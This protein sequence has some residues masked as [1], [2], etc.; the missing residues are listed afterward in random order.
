VLSS[1][2]KRIGPIEAAI[3]VLL[4]AGVTF[5]V[6]SLA[7]GGDKGPA[8]QVRAARAQSSTT[9]KPASGEVASVVVDAKTGK[10]RV[11]G[12][13]KAA[14]TG[15]K[16]E[17]QGAGAVAPAPA[18]APSSPPAAAT[19]STPS[20]ASAVG[21]MIVSPVT[22][23]T[24]DAPLLARVKAGHV[25]GIIL[26]GPNISTVTQVKALIGQLQGAAAAGGRPKLLI[27]TDQEGG[28][29]KRF[30][31]APPTSS[32]AAMGAAGPATAFQQGRLT[33]SALAQRGVN[34]D[35]APVADVPMV[36]HSF[37]GTRAFGTTPQR[38][39]QTSCQFAAGL[40]QGG[41]AGTLKHFPGLG[42]AVGNTDNQVVHIQAGTAAIVADLVPYRRCANTP[43]NLVMVSN[44]AYSSITGAAPAVVAP[45]AY[46]LLRTELG[47]QGVAIS[48]SLDARALAAVPNLA[49]AAAAAG[50]DLQLWTSAPRAQGAY[51]QLLSAAKDG[52]L[53]AAR[54]REAASR[55]HSLKQD[56]GLA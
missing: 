1:Q 28:D 53:P 21:Q 31:S 48:D 42:R 24:A 55:I 12:A 3:I 25:G 43:E 15:K 45:E 5:G 49:V 17:P 40:H 50:L 20:L 22:G 47:Y 29:V 32:A 37:L 14:K 13:L 18:A 52:R 6:L 38:V 19:A 10:V 46:Q 2:L 34:V 27:M 23:L 54:V 44:A 56:L 41:V 26:F 4:A 30:L 16:P 9:A 8:P 39:A 7:A 51:G 33:G 11:A 36:A 35:L